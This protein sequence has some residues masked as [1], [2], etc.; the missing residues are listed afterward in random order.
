MMVS[1][2]DG[3]TV[4]TGILAGVVSLLVGAILFYAAGRRAAALLI[5]AGHSDVLHRLSIAE[6]ELAVLRQQVVPISAAF[7]AVL[8][9]NL[10]HYHTPELDA[11]MVKLAP[12]TLTKEEFNRLIT[13]LDE[14]TRDMGPE[15][16]EEEREAAIILPYV[17]RRVRADQE[18]RGLAAEPLVRILVTTRERDPN[19]S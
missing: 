12:Y 7:Q 3:T 8:V 10:T 1:I 17:I 13:L 2:I 4:V 14:R 18:R 19:E 9:Q 6:T 11:L 5:A 15:I 16:S